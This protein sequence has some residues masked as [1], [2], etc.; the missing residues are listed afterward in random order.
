MGTKVDGEREKDKVK[1]GMKLCQTCTSLGENMILV[2][3]CESITN[4]ID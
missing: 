3:V 1:M 4:L 2:Y